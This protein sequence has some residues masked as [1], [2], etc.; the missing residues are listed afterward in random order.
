MSFNQSR[1]HVDSISYDWLGKNLYYTDNGLKQIG[2]V[3][4]YK[5]SSMPEMKISKVLFTEN[6][7]R[8]RAIIVHPVAGFVYVFE[9][10]S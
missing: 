6:L 10:F 1:S 9:F 5:I 7:G 8:P 3:R 2:V 4:A